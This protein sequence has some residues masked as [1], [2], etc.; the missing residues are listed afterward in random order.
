MASNSREGCVGSIGRSVG[1]SVVCCGG[2]GLFTAEG[3]GVEES[4]ADGKNED[5]TSM[6]GRLVRFARDTMNKVVSIVRVRADDTREE[7]LEGT[8]DGGW[9][10]GC[11]R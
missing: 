2:L 4:C 9:N 11:V 3:A 10:V 1:R 5:V 6:E 8:K 7:R